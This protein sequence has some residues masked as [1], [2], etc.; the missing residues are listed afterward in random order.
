MKREMT[1]TR[2][3]CVSESNE[4]IGESMPKSPT[5]SPES[6]SPSL[7][8]QIKKNSRPSNLLHVTINDKPLPEDFDYD[9]IS[10]HSNSNASSRRPSVLMQE[11]LQTRRPSAIMAALRSP[12]QFVNRYRRGYRMCYSNNFGRY[13]FY[14]FVYQ[15]IFFSNPLDHLST[16][17]TL[18]H[19]LMSMH[20]WWWGKI[21][22]LESRYWN[23]V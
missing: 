17:H 21:D 10:M 7:K 1:P 14:F 5:S 9:G 19:P 18:K 23:I 3:S 8:K 2:L 15:F 22:G 20:W 16:I 12:K 13:F 6:S 4:E 11:I